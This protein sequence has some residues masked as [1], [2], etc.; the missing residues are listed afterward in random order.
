MWADGQR[1]D[2]D[3]FGWTDRWLL[4]FA[5]ADYKDVVLRE[6]AIMLVRAQGQHSIRYRTRWP[7]GVFN[8][9]WK[10]TVARN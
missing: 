9:T 2:L 10:F 8:T 7:S 5:P 1:V 3:E 4:N 6:W